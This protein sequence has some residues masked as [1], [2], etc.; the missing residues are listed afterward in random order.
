M[1]AAKFLISRVNGEQVG[2][3]LES[4]FFFNNTLKWRI[5]EMLVDIAQQ[6]ILGVRILKFGFATQLD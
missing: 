4:V 3:K 6:V 2:E 5:E 1:A